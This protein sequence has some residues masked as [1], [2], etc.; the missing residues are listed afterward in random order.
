M[1]AWTMRFRNGK[2][3]QDMWPQCF[4]F[5]V[6]AIGYD[7]LAKTDLNQYPEK[8]PLTWGQVF[9]AYVGTLANSADK[10]ARKDQLKALDQLISPRR[11]CSDCGDPFDVDKHHPSRLRCPRYVNRCKQERHRTKRANERKT[12]EIR[13]EGRTDDT[14][15]GQ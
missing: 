8:E 1:T 5:G 4:K 14:S 2:A 15:S 11:P 3:G 10:A 13:S 6:A 7:P 9:G 12:L